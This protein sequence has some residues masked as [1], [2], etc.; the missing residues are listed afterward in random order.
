M[1]LVLIAGGLGASLVCNAF[2]LVVVRRQA[3]RIDALEKLVI[4]GV[5]DGRA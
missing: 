5:K 4:A 1:T 3:V 2:L